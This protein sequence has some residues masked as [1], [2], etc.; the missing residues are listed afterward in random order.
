[1]HRA[2]HTF[3]TQITRNN[4]TNNETTEIKY[5]KQFFFFLPLASNKINIIPKAFVSLHATKSKFF[6]TE[7]R[8][9]PNQRRLCCPNG[10]QKFLKHNNS[11]TE[12]ELCC[13]SVLS[14]YTF[15]IV[16]K[17]KNSSL[18]VKKKKKYI[19][20]FFDNAISILF[21]TIA[22][23]SV[24]LQRSVLSCF[25]STRYKYIRSPLT[26]L[27]FRTVPFFL[28]LLTLQR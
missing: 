3:Y 17:F 6:R 21:F 5:Q 27:Y 1:M 10:R 13:T 15:I 28:A 19:L 8:R 18:T 2:A 26:N 22:I 11:V 20:W 4:R 25:P 24:R 14:T 12:Y 7:I 9:L 23:F 16:N